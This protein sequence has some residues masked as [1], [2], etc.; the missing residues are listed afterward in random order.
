VSTNE[1]K[2]GG[3]KEGVAPK[4][5]PIRVKGEVL[6]SDYIIR[7]T[8]TD[9]IFILPPTNSM[10]RAKFIKMSTNVRRFC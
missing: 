1:S 9:F 3:A 2:G 5:Q 7:R 6:R 8:D 10:Q 4:F